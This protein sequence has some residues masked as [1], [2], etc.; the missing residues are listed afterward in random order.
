MAL[1]PHGHLERRPPAAELVHQVHVEVRVLQDRT[2]RR[3]AEQLL[4]PVTVARDR[5][6]LDH[7]VP[8]VHLDAR[9]R[10]RDPLD[11]DL[12]VLFEIIALHTL[13]VVLQFPRT[14]R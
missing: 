6:E 5:R 10:A 12:D 4:V 9:M 13:N 14:L 11:G 2:V 1:P 7:H 3:L 8:A